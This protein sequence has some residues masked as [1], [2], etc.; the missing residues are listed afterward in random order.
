ML[1]ISHPP[2]RRAEREYIYS[3]I[4]REF[5]GIEFMSVEHPG[6]VTELSMADP[7]LPGNIT[8]PDVL[9]STAEGKWLT[10]A[11]L[12]KLPLRRCRLNH[13]L[14]ALLHHGSVPIL[15]GAEVDHQ[16]LYAR[17]NDTLATAI[18]IPGSVFFMLTRYEEAVMRHNDDHGRFPVASSVVFRSGLTDRALVNELVEVLWSMMTTLWP[19]LQ[20]KQRTYRLVPTHDVDVPVWSSNI[21]PARLIRSAVMDLVI[22]RDGKLALQRFQSVAAGRRGDHRLDPNNTYEFIMECSERANL[23]STFFLKAGRSSAAYDTAM[24]VDNARMRSLIRS[25]YGRGHEIGLHPSYET[26]DKPEMIRKEFAE[27][28]RVCDEEQVEQSLWGGRQHYLRWGNPVTWQNYE[29]AGLT[30]DSS[31]S[32]AGFPGFRTGCCYEYSCFNLRTRKR[33]QLRERPLIVMDSNIFT[34]FAQPT[35]QSMEKIF[36]FAATCKAF[37]GDFTILWHNSSL[38][39]RK[40]RDA[41]QLMLGECL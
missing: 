40:Q 4:F 33:L 14:Q 31:L 12:P 25:V 23:R 11:S 26:F 17:V 9:L 22:R 19:G 6:T 20:R 2:G 8:M 7:P 37:R 27:L 41:Y 30:Y 38:I 5:L 21:N 13:A 36:Q 15:Y 16:V 18:D 35:R 34:F 3:V 32:F 1:I 28:Q 29:D 10:E 39:S 24:L